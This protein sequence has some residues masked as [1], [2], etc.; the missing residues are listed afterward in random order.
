MP[1]VYL[2]DELDAVSIFLTQRDVI[3]TIQKNGLIPI[4]SIKY[5]LILCV[6]FI[7]NQITTLILRMESN[8]IP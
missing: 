6:F 3:C 2:R 1:L 4:S 7:F 8:G 5:I